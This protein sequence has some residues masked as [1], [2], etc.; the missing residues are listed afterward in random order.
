MYHA[1]AAIA[2]RDQAAATANVYF[3]EVSLSVDSESGTETQLNSGNAVA[4]SSSTSDDITTILRKVPTGSDGVAGKSAIKAM[5]GFLVKSL[6]TGGAIQFTVN[7]VPLFDTTTNGSGT[8]LDI[9][10]QNKGLDVAAINSTIN[11]TRATNANV[12]L[13]AKRGGEST[14]V[15]TL[16][17]YSSGG[18]TATILGQ[19]YTTT[20]AN[21][22]AVSATNYGVGTDELFTLTVGGNS[23]T[24][25]VG[26]YSTTATTLNGIASLMQAAWA[27]KYGSAGTASASAIATVTTIDPG[28]INITML[29]QDSAGYGV[30][31][32]F[33]VASGS[34][35]TG[36][37]TSTTGNNIDYTI[38]SSNLESDD[39]TTDASIIVTIESTVAGVDENTISTLT[40]STSDANSTTIVELATTFTSNSTFDSSTYASTQ[41]ERT[42]VRTAEDGT[43]G[44]SATAAVVYSRVHWLG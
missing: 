22:A 37:D 36:L 9:N 23:V 19:K 7:G 24:A 10:G 2:V 11:T 33:A 26:D 44:T 4:F 28:V 6:D 34:A 25:S 1:T 38:G 42:D 16:K 5:R 40:T 39:A 13:L 3:D 18:S 27:Y 29:Q 35:T 17:Q 12:T 31:V 15:V 41:V 14:G 21:A 43:T 32:D 30:N 20:T 8:A